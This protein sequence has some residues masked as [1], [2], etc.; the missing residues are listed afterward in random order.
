MGLSGGK[1]KYVI[2]GNKACQGKQGYSRDKVTQMKHGQSKETSDGKQ[3]S[4]NARV[5]L[6]N[7]ATLDRWTSRM[8]STI[9]ERIH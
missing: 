8:E 5:K 1:H 9:A 6:C 3:S 2:Y 4:A 7:L